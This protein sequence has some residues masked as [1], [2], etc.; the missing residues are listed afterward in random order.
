MQTILNKWGKFPQKNIIV[1]IFLKNNKQPVQ[2]LTI[3]RLFSQKFE[4]VFFKQ[5][6]YLFV[7]SYSAGKN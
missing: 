3:S 2:I 5:L 6:K 7:Y 4:T 1:Q